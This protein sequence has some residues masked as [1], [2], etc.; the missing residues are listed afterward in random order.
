MLSVFKCSDGGAL[1]SIAAGGEVT[2]Y[3]E[4]AVLDHR[5]LQPSGV[6]VTTAVYFALRWQCS[7]LLLSELLSGFTPLSKKEL[8]VEQ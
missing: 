1:P 5:A 8:L 2:G 7:G 3:I 6:D 4:Q